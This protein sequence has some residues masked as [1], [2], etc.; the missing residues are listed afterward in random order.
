MTNNMSL[1]A[2]SLCSQL[3]KRNYKFFSSK[4]SSKDNE[5]HAI[6]ASIRFDSDRL[7]RLPRKT[8]SFTPY[9]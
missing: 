9:G 3:W 7:D 1:H 5:N 6:E 2:S 8:Q 4:S